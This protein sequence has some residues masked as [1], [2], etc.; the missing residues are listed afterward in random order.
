MKKIIYTGFA[1]MTTLLFWGCEGFL[2]TKSYTMKDTSNFPQT[3]SDAES[4]LTGIYTTF[5]KAI[6]NVA[7]TSFFVAELASDDRFGGGGDNDKLV[8]SIDHLMNYKS[9]GSADAFWKAR[10]SGILRANML[11]ETINNC[12]G[13]ESEAQKN[14]FEGE[15]YFLRAIF[16]FDL[17]QLFG[18]VPLVLSSGA[19]NMPK[20]P[21]D[22][23]YAQIASDLKN[24]I[25]KMYSTPYTTVTSGHA[26]KWAAEALMARVFLFYTGYYGKDSLPLTDGGSITKDQVVTW[27]EDCI[28]NS[29]HGLVDDFR[30]LWPYTNSYTVEEY[31]YTKGKGLVW[32]DNGNKETVFS[33]K[34]GILADWGDQYTLGY[35]NQYNLFFG[36]RQGSTNNGTEATFP[37]GPGWGAGPV[38]TGLWNEWRT[39]EPNDIRRVASILDAEAELADYGYGGDSQMEETGY[40]AKKYI[41]V[42]A[43]NGGAWIGSYTIAK[44]GA[45]TDMQLFNTQ[46]LILI[47]FAD[48]LL[49]HSEL[50]Q[51]ATNM[52][53]VRA[54]VGLPAVSYSL[55]AIKKERRFELAFEGLRYYDLMRWGDAATALAKQEGINIYNKGVATVMKAMGGGYAARYNATGGFRPIPQTQI[56]LSAGLLEQNKGWDVS[57][58]NYTNW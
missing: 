42:S 28:N 26:T 46:D 51:D 53:K 2:D 49:M 52:N 29:G 14:Q 54:R 23:T 58:A 38:N 35:S 6:D 11:L 16:Y 25:E 15:A 41:P 57:D 31:S 18:E 20:S 5:S 21:A 50:K 27:L 22:E 8:Q 13:W 40:W 33:I 48:V 32:A 56:D 9:D 7:Q 44:D 39:A 30:E 1:I 43:Y 3:V 34:F 36:L 24:A 55:D 4:S 10:Y 37:F 12:S 45:S 19:E 47:R 17:S